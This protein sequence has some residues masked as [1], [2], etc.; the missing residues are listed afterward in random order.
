[1]DALQ[2]GL[3]TVLSYRES[4]FFGGPTV[5]LFLADAQS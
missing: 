4:P 1:L 3:F 5:D 2:S